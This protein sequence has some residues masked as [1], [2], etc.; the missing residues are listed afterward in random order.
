MPSIRAARSVVVVGG[1]MRNAR[2]RLNLDTMERSAHVRRCLLC[3]ELLDGCAMA[4]ED[5]YVEKAAGLIRAHIA[6]GQGDESVSCPYSGCV[7]HESVELPL[8][9][10]MIRVGCG[11]RPRPSIRGVKVSSIALVVTDADHPEGFDMTGQDALQRHFI[12]LKPSAG[13]VFLSFRPESCR[14]HVWLSPSYVSRHESVEDPPTIEDI[15]KTFEKRV[16]ALRAW[17]LRK[18]AELKDLATMEVALR[19]RTG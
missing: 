4:V 11:D 10:A 2:D 14:V 13:D 16:P 6:G 5:D 3:K 8:A 17:C 7:H 9:R 1:S 19:R 15:L 12:Y 18:Y